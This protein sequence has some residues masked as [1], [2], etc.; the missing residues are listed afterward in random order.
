LNTGAQRDALVDLGLA[1]MSERIT[2]GTSVQ[3]TYSWMS[4]EQALSAASKNYTLCDMFSFGL[5]VKWLI[6]GQASDVPFS[7]SSTDQIILE[8]RRL[9]EHGSDSGI[10]HPYVTDLHNVPPVFRPL[11][12][13]CA[14]VLPSKRWTAA[15]ALCELNVIASKAFASASL[16]AVSAAVGTCTVGSADVIEEELEEL[17]VGPKK[18]CLAFARSLGDAR[19]PA[20]VSA[21]PA[22]A[23]AKVRRAS[24]CTHFGASHCARANLTPHTLF[25]FCAPSL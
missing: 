11:I 5:I 24:L 14:S 19:A 12:Q 6:V 20:P 4:P 16:V 7:D 10:M 9:H 25:C 22:P 13:G 21:A 3:G 15:A 17:E 1:K 18:A 8:H 2:L 23:P